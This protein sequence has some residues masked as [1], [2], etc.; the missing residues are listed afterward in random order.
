MKEPF[1]LGDRFYGMLFYEHPF[2]V[3]WTIIAGPMQFGNF[4]IYDVS[5]EY[6][7]TE[8][9]VHEGYLYSMERLDDEII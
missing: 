9:G 2:K 7:H 5:D 4:T 1:K 3:V 6:D 8:Y